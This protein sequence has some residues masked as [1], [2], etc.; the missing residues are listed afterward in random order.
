MPK[1]PFPKSYE[2]GE[3]IASEVVAA[4]DPSKTI[5]PKMAT[6]A[7]RAAAITPTT[8]LRSASFCSRQNSS[9]EVRCRS[10]PTAK[11]PPSWEGGMG[12]ANGRGGGAALQPRRRAQARVSA[13]DAAGRM[14][15]GCNLA[16]ARSTR[17]VVLPVGSRRIGRLLGRR[18]LRRRCARRSDERWER[19]LYV[20][21]VPL[22]IP[23]GRGD[24][25][26]IGAEPRPG[27]PGGRPTCA[28][29]ACCRRGG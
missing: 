5:S 14:A 25:V 26:I 11:Q 9:S 27:A 7:G 28:A 13:M 1:K 21:V 23:P 3:V 15:S 22:Q 12:A 17:L 19:G 16:L 2:V 20:V 24:F 29:R 8:R 4:E 6:K 18:R 10:L